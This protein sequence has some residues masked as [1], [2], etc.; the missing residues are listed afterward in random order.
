MVKPNAELPWGNHFAFLN[1]PLPKLRDAGAENPLHFVFK[2]RQIIKRKRMSTFVV[3]LTAK[4]LQLGASK[5]IRGIMMSTSME[6]TN[7]MGLIEKMALASDPVKG[8][9]FVMTGT[10]Q[11]GQYHLT[12]L[13]VLNIS[14]I[15]IL[16]LSQQ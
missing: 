2:A 4:Y 15:T 11:A 6:I 5:H 13:P 9:Y 12:L 14:A 10:P 7:V 3:F 16:V 8:L 1:I